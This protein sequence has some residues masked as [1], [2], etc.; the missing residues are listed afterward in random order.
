MHDPFTMHMPQSS[1]QSSHY[2]PY[3]LFAESSTSI[4][5]DVIER[6]PSQQLQDHINRVIR[7]VNS[8]YL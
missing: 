1:K 3:L 8:L 2:I 4:L 7:L 5:N 6:L